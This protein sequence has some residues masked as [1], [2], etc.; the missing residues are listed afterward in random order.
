MLVDA[1][2]WDTQ[3]IIVVEISAANDGQILWDSNSV[4]QRIIHG[5]RCQRIVEAE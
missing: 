1:G 3:G 2:E 4:I 5:G